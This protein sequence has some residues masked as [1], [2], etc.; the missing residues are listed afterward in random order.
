MLTTLRFERLQAEHIPTILEIEQQ[1]NSAPWSE[2]S[3][4][5]EI[6]HPHGYFLV[7]LVQGEVVAYGGIWMVIDE[8]H[9]ITIAV[10]EAH[11]RQGIARKMMINLLEEAMD[12][13]ILCAS[14]EVRA[15]NHAA[16]EL[17]EKLGFVQTTRRKAYYPDNKED[18]VVMWLHQLATWNPS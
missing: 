9:V 12:K 15:S 8:A 18:A 16:I 6:D 14:L 10:D 2:R 13:G 17:Y 3:F 4:T 7:A 5:N 11:R 1:A